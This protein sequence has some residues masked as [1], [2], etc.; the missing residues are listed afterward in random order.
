MR[1]LVL[2][3]VG[4]MYHLKAT[5]ARTSNLSSH[6]FIYL[7]VCLFT[8]RVLSE[9]Q[10][11]R[12]GLGEEKAPGRPHCGLPLLEGSVYTGGGQTFYMV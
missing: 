7:F 12:D 8:C 10:A 9:I 4:L 1:P 11:E 2:I 5:A 6:L 3:L